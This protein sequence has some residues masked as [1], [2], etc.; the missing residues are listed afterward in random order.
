MSENE[1]GELSYNDKLKLT[2]R[3]DELN[4]LALAENLA[5]L[6]Q[7]YDQRI[8]FLENEVRKLN[9]IVQGQTQVIGTAIGQLWGSGS[10]E[11]E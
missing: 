3:V 7:H 11:R 1:N 4:A 5:E 6:R 9:E 2:A 10:T 8:E